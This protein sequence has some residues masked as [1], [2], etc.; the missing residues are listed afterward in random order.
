MKLFGLNSL[1]K[2]QKKQKLKTNEYY[3][4]ELNFNF[5]VRIMNII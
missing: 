1:S 4:T 3:S 2:K 5:P